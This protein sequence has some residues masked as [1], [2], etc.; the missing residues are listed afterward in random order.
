MPYLVV[1]ALIGVIGGLFAAGVMEGF[2]AL[3]AKP[4]GQVGR[5][6]DSSTVKAADA[7]GRVATGKPVRQGWRV[8]AGR[9]VHYATGAALGLVY[10]GLATVWMPATLGFGALFGVVTAL[11]L[12]EMIVPAFGLGP[13]PWQTPIATHA[14][15]LSAH[16]VFGLALEV[17]RRFGLALLT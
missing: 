14:Y 1:A 17:A 3:V 16:V 13:P 6:D 7:L 5:P 12:D 8:R 10:V 11:I 4:F 2:Q 9:L 15:S